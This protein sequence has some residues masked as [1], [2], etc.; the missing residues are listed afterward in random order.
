MKGLPFPGSTLT[1]AHAE[2]STVSATGENGLWDDEDRQELS[3]RARRELSVIEE[4]SSIAPDAPLDSVEGGEE[5][6]PRTIHEEE[7]EEEAEPRMIQEEE[8]E[9]DE[10]ADRDGEPEDEEPALKGSV[11]DDTEDKRS[12]ASTAS[13]PGRVREQEE[14]DN[15]V[16]TIT[17]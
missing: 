6:E 4:A 15:P 7:Q 9:E 3:G 17:S 11:E 1:P 16:I 12:E 10:L 14:G 2:T 5:V 13:V 8:A